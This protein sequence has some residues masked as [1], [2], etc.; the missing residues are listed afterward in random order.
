MTV[1]LPLRMPGTCLTRPLKVFAAAALCLAT[2]TGLAQAETSVT[3]EP[4]SRFQTFEG[5]ETTVNLYFNKTPERYGPI[6]FDKLLREVGITRLRLEIAAGAENE[7]GW[8]DD[9]LAGRTSVDDQRPIFYETRNDND[10]PF[11]SDPAG[12]DFGVLDYKYETFVVPMMERAKALGLPLTVNLCYVSFTKFIRDG[13]QY[14]H[15]QPEEYAEFI[16]QVFLHLRDKYGFV[17]AAF[18][19]NLE[20]DLSP[21]WTP[22][23]LG[24]AMAAVTRRLK[25]DGFT[26]P[27]IAPSVTNASHV[28]PWMDGISAVPGATDM[29]TELSFHRYKGASRAVVSEIANRAA[30]AGWRTGMLEFWGGR[31]TP[32]VLMDDLTIGNVSAWQGR[33]ML[34]FY[35]INPSLPEGQDM[36]IFDDVRMNLPF[37]QSIRPGAVRIGAVSSAPQSV[38]AVAFENPGGK[39][40]V[41]VLS[42]APDTV[43]FQALPPGS[44]RVLQAYADGSSTPTDPATVGPDGTLTVRLLAAG[45]VA[46]T[47]LTAN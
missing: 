19:V 39:L 38:R 8:I 15:D 45:V 36:A 24:L 42:D 13:G 26:M 40:S 29:M 10:D 6:I 25:A 22:E 21:E 32:D 7:G 12:F 20:P 23:K 31:G 17:P 1:G 16:E 33:A 46:V 27:L 37:F 41:V 2:A 3:L 4:D 47:A 5:W 28:G 18:E 35:K 34:G 9:L 43:T 11:V 30:E 44:Y 14:I